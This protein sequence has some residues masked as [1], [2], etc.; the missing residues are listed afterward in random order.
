ME[1]E[2][3]FARIEVQWDGEGDFFTVEPC[4]SEVFHRIGHLTVNLDNLPA[5]EPVEVRTLWT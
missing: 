3:R 4:C 2:H 5:N 1:D